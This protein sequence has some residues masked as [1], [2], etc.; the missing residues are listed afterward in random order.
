VID[1]R[2]IAYR[3]RGRVY[4]YCVRPVIGEAAY[5]TRVRV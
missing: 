3:R 5:G 1:C 4:R 2:W